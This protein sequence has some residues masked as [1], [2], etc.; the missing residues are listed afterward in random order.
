M[1]K[2]RRSYLFFLILMKENLAH[3]QKTYHGEE[4]LL[5]VINNQFGYT[6]FPMTRLL[7]IANF[8]LTDY[9]QKHSSPHSVCNECC[10]AALEKRKALQ[11]KYP[12]LPI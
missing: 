9:S 7:D 4:S 6:N 12:A 8:A 5:K 11:T 3:I 10:K 1:D 2:R